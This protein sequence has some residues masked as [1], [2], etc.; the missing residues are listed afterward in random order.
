MVELGERE[1]YQL[2]EYVKD[3]G[4]YVMMPAMARKRQVEV[5]KR[6]ALLKDYA[7][8]SGIN[9]IEWGDK[10]IGVITSGVSY[11]YS[12]EALGDVS[13]L[14]LGMVYPFPDK[15]IKEFA[16]QVET[17]YVIEELQPFFEEHIKSLG[18]NVIGKEILPAT[19]E[20]SARLLKEKIL[21]IKPEES[22]AIN[23]TAS[24]RPPVLCPGCPHRGMFYVL[25]KLKV[26]VSGDIGCYT[27]GALPPTN[28]MDTCICMGASIGVAHGMEKARGKDFARKTV[29]ILGDSTFIHSGITGLIDIV[30]NKGT[31]TVIVLDNSITGMTGH[32]HNPTT[33]FT[34]KGEP[35][36]QVNIELLA[37]AVGI[38]RVRVVDP[39]NIKEFEKVVKEEIN[40]E[41]PSVI[42]SQ[43]PCALL[44]SVKYEGPFKIDTEKCTRCKMCMKISCP[45]IVD[46][47][48]RIE[49]NEALC[50]G[51]DLCTKLCNFGAIGKAGEQ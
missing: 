42:V 25:N 11:Q 49:I 26:N 12:K 3:P 30:Y 36:K 13:Y 50:V 15:L 31:S 22:E 14:K 34:I 8:E 51:C 45:A 32:Q 2:K 47:G 39:F 7:N 43:R 17:L 6:M 20:Y 41:E 33:G 18:I 29:A 48:D 44:K 9:K 40:A 21:N 28:G 37:K 10:K 16:S 38:E 19:G 1:E 46:L 23:E 5:E 4:K 35:T 24:P 27:L